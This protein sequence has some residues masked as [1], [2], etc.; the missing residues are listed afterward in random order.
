MVG[1]MAH[2]GCWGRRGGGNTAPN[3]GE[4]NMG[5]PGHLER[6]T[7]SLLLLC[8]DLSEEGEECKACLFEFQDRVQ[9]IW[10]GVWR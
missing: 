3:K 4:M 6:I 5:L 1:C 7:D 2:S 8:N 10:I 9:S